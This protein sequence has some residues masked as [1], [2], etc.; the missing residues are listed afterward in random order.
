[1]GALFCSPDGRQSVSSV[2]E[3]LRYKFLS[4]TA[5]RSSLL[6]GNGSSRFCA[7]QTKMVNP[8]NNKWSIHYIVQDLVAPSG[9]KGHC[10]HVLNV[11]CTD[12]S[13]KLNCIQWNKCGLRGRSADT[14]LVGFSVTFVMSQR[15]GSWV[16]QFFS[17]L[18][19]TVEIRGW[20]IIWLVGHNGLSHLT[21]RNYNFQEDCENITS[22][23]F[24]VNGTKAKHMSHLS[25]TV[26]FQWNNSQSTQEKWLK[27]SYLLTYFLL[28]S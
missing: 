25:P 15:E 23:S 22:C 17:F 9:Q 8:E 18:Q 3:L 14:N 11:S 6:P 1:M 10:K 26:V 13:G 24:D 19:E 20:K 21:K 27:F 4:V 2:H 28:I 5:N 12:L 16:R 7:K